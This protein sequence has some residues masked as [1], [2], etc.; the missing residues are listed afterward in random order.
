MLIEPLSLDE[1]N[2]EV[3]N[4]R[5]GLATASATATEICARMLEEI[6]LTASAGI[7]YNKILAQLASKPRAMQKSTAPHIAAD[8]RVHKACAASRKALVT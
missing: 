8:V 7:S 3:T 1:A 5:R 6:G 4:N 2:L